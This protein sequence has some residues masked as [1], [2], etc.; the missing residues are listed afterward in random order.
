MYHWGTAQER[1]CYPA[2][3]SCV[4]ASQGDP[5]L[6][7]HSLVELQSTRLDFPNQNLMTT[8]ATIRKYNKLCQ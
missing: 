1:T 3:L 2:L 7:F 5:G 6:L 8:C 4:H